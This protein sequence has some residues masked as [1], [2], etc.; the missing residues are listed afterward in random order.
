MSS[1]FGAV[2][3]GL[4]A[5]GS[6]LA[7]SLLPVTLAFAATGIIPKGAGGAAT[8]DFVPNTVNVGDT[9]AGSLT[10][11]NLGIGGTG[12]INQTENVLVTNIF[13]TPSCGGG[14]GVCTIGQEDPGVFV[15]SNPVADPTTACAGKTFTIVVHDAT[16]GELQF[17]PNTPV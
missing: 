6:L 1:E 8:P 2:R 15:I 17:V 14:S 7:L 9:F 5:L 16:T 4:L 10:L 11:T 3:R 13:L 12:N